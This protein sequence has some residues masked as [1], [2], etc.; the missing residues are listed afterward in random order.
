MRERL[1][2]VSLR[3]PVEAIRL[4]AADFT[5]LHERS[6]AMFGDAAADEESWVQ[7]AERLRV[8]LGS[9]AIHGLT[10]QPDHRPEHAW[11][12]VEFELLAGPERIECGWWD[13][14]EAKRDYFIARAG[15]CSLVWIYRESGN[16][17]LHGFFA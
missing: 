13:G 16:W 17:Y 10:T 8:R 2:T 9:G 15:D 1:A 14:D 6:G 12:C 4:E 5:P 7:L 3:E 11:R